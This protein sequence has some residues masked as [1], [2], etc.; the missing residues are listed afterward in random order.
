MNDRI[1][2]RLILEAIQEVLAEGEG[3]PGRYEKIGYHGQKSSSGDAHEKSMKLTGRGKIYKHVLDNEPIDVKTFEKKYGKHPREIFDK[4]EFKVVGGQLSL[5][6]K[7][8][9]R[10][11]AMVGKS[12]DDDE[13]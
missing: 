10:T 7:G 3:K 2:K 11:K 1:L 6:V 8:R 12:V 5:T 9:D 13:D 4:G